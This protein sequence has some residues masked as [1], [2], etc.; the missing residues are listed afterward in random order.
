MKV[1]LFMIVIGII[2][3]SCSSKL[4]LKIDKRVE[5][6]K[7]NDLQSEESYETKLPVKSNST[8]SIYTSYANNNYYPVDK[9]NFGEESIHLQVIALTNYYSAEDYKNRL[10]LAPGLSAYIKRG[11][12]NKVIITGIKSIAEAN[13]LKE[14]YFP[15]SFIV[16]YDNLSS[17]DNYPTP[18]ASN[19]SYD[20]YASGSYTTNN[21][22]NYGASL[23]NTVK[24]GVEI[25][26]YMTLEN[27]KEL[28]TLKHMVTYILFSR[29]PKNIK[30]KARYKKVL[31]L[32][33]TREGRTHITNEDNDKK[34]SK[35][36]RFIIPVTNHNKGINLENY[37]YKLSE[38]ILDYLGERYGYKLFESEGPYFI[39]TRDRLF[40]DEKDLNILYLNLD[41]FDQ[42]AIIETIKIYKD[43]LEDIDKLKFTFL[44]DLKFKIL[45]FIVPANENINNISKLISEGIVGRAY[46]E[47]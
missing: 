3:N 24:G 43:R 2:F 11:S 33:A 29:E 10:L 36:N 12:L 20:P 17:S 16:N 1:Y 13:R 47:E 9:N 7:S 23:L 8:Y 38:K 26:R 4:S 14:R 37:N 44:D 5:Y 41:K 32:I 42:S 21:S 46:A 6:L 39:T 30:V 18:Y 28:N 45:A 35:M 25:H 15:G 34:I 31:D 22:Y 40:Q 27:Q 19:A